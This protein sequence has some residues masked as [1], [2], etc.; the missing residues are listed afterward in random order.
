M[1]RKNVRRHRI[2]DEKT[3]DDSSNHV[4]TRQLGCRG[5]I[6]RYAHFL[7]LTSEI[8]GPGLDVDERSERATMF[9]RPCIDWYAWH[10]D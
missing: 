7:N 6:E 1:V 5:K 9:R 4:N 2:A 8:T 10:G 3:T